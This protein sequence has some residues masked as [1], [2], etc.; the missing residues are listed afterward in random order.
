MAKKKAMSKAEVKKRAKEIEAA[1]ENL[2]KDL[3]LEEVF[4][5]YIGGDVGSAVEADA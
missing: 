1:F 5:R 2:T 4:L 3:T